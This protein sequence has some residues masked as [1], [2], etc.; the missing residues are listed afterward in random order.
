ME[1]LNY[2]G[3]LPNLRAHRK[4]NGGVEVTVGAVDGVF[5]H[6]IGLVESKVVLDLLHIFETIVANT[7]WILGVAR[8]CSSSLRKEGLLVGAVRTEDVPALPAMM[9]PGNPI[10]IGQ[11]TRT[12][13]FL[14]IGDPPWSNITFRMRCLSGL[15]IHLLLIHLPIFSLN[16]CMLFG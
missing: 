3:C 11:A 5:S 13:V 6:G 1:I 16:L 8:F 14:Q 9:P 15:Y 10:K 2:V 4:A 7:P 12:L